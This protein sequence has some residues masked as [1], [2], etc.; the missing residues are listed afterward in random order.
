MI[1]PKAQD[2]SAIIINGEQELQC[3]NEG[4]DGEE[5][6]IVQNAHKAPPEN[7]YRSVALRSATERTT[8]KW[9]DSIRKKTASCAPFDSDAL[10][11]TLLN[12]LD[13]SNFK[14]LSR[15]SG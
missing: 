7:F 10:D 14:A 1:P 2:D 12:G 15:S 13:Y 9:Y 3:Q 6:D 8:Q 4:D 11:Q 5:K